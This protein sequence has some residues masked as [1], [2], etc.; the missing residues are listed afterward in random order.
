[1][2][3]IEINEEKIYY[4]CDTQDEEQWRKGFIAVTELGSRWVAWKRMSELRPIYTDTYETPD[5]VESNGK[6]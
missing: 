2:E 5:K 3:F 6:S 1:V 4:L